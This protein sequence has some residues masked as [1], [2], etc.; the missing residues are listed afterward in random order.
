MAAVNFS[1]AVGD[2]VQFNENHKWRGCIGII[3]EVKPLGSDNEKYLIGI[4]AP[5]GGVIYA[6]SVKSEA[7]IDYIG[8]ALYVPWE[9]K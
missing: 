4:P 9:G 8:H 5:Q 7:E 3:E 1:F 2:V 6:F